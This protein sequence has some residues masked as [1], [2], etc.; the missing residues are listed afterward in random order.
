MVIWAKGAMVRKSNRSAGDD[1]LSWSQFWGIGFFFFFS[2]F[3]FFCFDFILQF[4]LGHF[5]LTPKFCDYFNKFRCM[6][7]GVLS[8]LR[9]FLKSMTS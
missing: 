1:A 6:F 7:G 2:F 9:S 3:F 8:Q 4:L 5:D